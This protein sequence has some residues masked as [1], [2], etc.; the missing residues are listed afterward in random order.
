MDIS[1]E[2]CGRYP[3]GAWIRLFRPG[4]GEGMEGGLW[5]RLHADV[6][7]TIAAAMLGDAFIWYAVPLPLWPIETA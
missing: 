7:A 1:V 5:D 4:R 6:E 3:P 2:Y